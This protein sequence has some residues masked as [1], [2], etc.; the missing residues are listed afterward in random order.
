VFVYSCEVGTCGYG[1][2]FGFHNVAYGPRG[3]TG[4]WHRAKGKPHGVT[5]K[6]HST[7]GTDSFVAILN[8]HTGTG[9]GTETIAG[10][11]ATFTALENPA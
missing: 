9:S 3:A 4:T 6:F 2:S 1:Y 10:V 11:T 7:S 8:P 5:I